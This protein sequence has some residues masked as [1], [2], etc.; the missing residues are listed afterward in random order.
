MEARSVVHLAVVVD[1][2]CPERKDISGTFLEF[3]VGVVSRFGIPS[4]LIASIGSWFRIKEGEIVLMPCR[5]G[6]EVRGEIMGVLYNCK[7]VVLQF[8]AVLAAS[9]CVAIE[10]VA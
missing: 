4:L 7:A 5:D 3:Q 9:E 10:I 6:S 2:G 8:E 1:V